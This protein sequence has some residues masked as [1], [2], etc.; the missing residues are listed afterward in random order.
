[1][2]PT[3]DKILFLFLGWLL[4]M[5]S[6]VIV[7]AI[8][9]RRE[10][11]LGRAAILT[12]LNELAA[13]LAIAVYGARSS[14]GTVDRPF[15]EWLQTFLDSHPIPPTLQGFKS[16]LPV[17]LSWSDEDIAKGAQHMANAPGT[18]AMLQH[19]PV[20]LLDSRVSAIWTFNT[21]FQRRLL[22]IRRN[23]AL[24]DDIVDR[25]RKYFDLTFTKLEAD[26]HDL[27]RDN[28][29]QC[30][31]LYAARATTVVEQITELRRGGR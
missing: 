19:Y 21:E 18:S 23:V 26:N 3:L 1:M 27:V 9:R 12:E 4:G 15:L 14:L 24:L 13:T 17:H 8:A 25:S 10:N 31:E 16:R 5:L 22:E 7:A 28:I 6:P 11:A 2:D 30:C 29:D 20:P